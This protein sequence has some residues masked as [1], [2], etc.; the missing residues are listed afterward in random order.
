MNSDLKTTRYL[1]KVCAKH[2]EL[3]GERLKSTKACLGCKRQRD[4]AYQAKKLATDKEFKEKHAAR[5]RKNIAFRR[6]NDK[7]FLETTRKRARE[8][9][10]KK[11]A[12]D[13]GFRAGRMAYNSIRDRD[14]IRARPPWMPWKVV[15]KEYRIAS[16]LG[17]TIDHIVPIRHPLVCGLHVP[18]N[19]QM[20][21]RRENSSKNN[22]FS[23]E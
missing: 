8:S 15:A 19:F 9:N 21:T 11:W 4:L 22:R 2:P 20:M 12:S 18:W 6:A 7:D 1:G 10:V 17:L 23:V 14:T 5:N 3:N 13:P 16:E